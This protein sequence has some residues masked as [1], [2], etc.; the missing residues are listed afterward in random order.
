MA[1]LTKIFTGMEKGPEAIQA[2]FDLMDTKINTLIA[3]TG[4]VKVPVING[5]QGD[6]SVRLQNGVVYHKGYFGSDG[7]T[8]NISLT[9]FKYPDSFGDM[10]DFGQSN[11]GWAAFTSDGEP[12]YGFIKGATKEF[13]CLKKGT[14]GMASVSNITFKL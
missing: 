3:D 4:W 1:E 7:P 2:N 9:V 8:I 12:N 13:F 6:I 14:K 11:G 5:W 10:S